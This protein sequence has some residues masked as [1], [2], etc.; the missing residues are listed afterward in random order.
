MT[1]LILFYNDIRYAWLHDIFD[2]FPIVRLLFE[3]LKYPQ[4]LQA[5]PFRRTSSS[6]QLTHH[7]VSFWSQFGH[8]SGLVLVVARYLGH[9]LVIVVARCLRHAR[10]RV[11]RKLSYRSLHTSG[12][13]PLSGTRMFPI[14][15]WTTKEISGGF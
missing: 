6:G 13:P 1:L 7:L 8:I 9:G 5:H 14:R 4:K 15:L 10:W 2:Y 11:V 3:M 12:M